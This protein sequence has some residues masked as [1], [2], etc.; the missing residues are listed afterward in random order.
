MS[1]VLETAKLFWD[2]MKDGAKLSTSGTTVTVVPQGTKM[3]DH[4]GWQGPVSFPEHYEELSAIFDSDLARFTLTP[5]WQFNGQYIGNFNV[6]VDGSLDVLSSL[7][8]SVTTLE[9]SSDGD[10][11]V[12]LPYHIDVRFHNVTGGTK[13]T[14]FRAIARGDGGGR[15]LA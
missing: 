15:S 1:A 10:D 11:I 9:A 6:M 8:V 3:K 7:D 5:N 4:S 2:V 12:E 13:A 14:T